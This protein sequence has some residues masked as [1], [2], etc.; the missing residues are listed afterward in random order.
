M[1]LCKTCGTANEKSTLFCVDCG[2]AIAK[3]KPK[4]KILIASGVALAVVAIGATAYVLNTDVRFSAAYKSLSSLC[5]V[6][7]GMDSPITTPDDARSYSQRI[8]N[9]LSD[10]TSEDE[11]RAKPFQFIPSDLI[12]YAQTVED[13]T[14]AEAM[15][16]IQADPWGFLTSGPV[17]YQTVVLPK[18]ISNESVNIKTD[19]MKLCEPF[20][21]K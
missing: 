4:A 12:S 21:A 8:S 2:T 3:P 14:E 5:D 18:S 19:A 7:D 1:N 16:Q 10:A 11:S 6:V 15:R 17:I 20:S 9:L 13:F